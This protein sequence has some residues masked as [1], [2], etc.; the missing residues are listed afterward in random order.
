MKQ[1]FE[2]GLDEYRMMRWRNAR[3][4]GRYRELNNQHP[5]DTKYGVFF[6]FGKQQ[7]A[8]GLQKLI[9]RGYINEGEEQKL[10]SYA[11]FLYG[12][13]SELK[14]FMNSYEE[15]RKRIAIECD[16]QEVYCYEFNNFECGTAFDGDLNA[17]L[18]VADIWGTDKA[19]TITRA[20]VLYSTEELFD[21][22]TE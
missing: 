22:T 21:K 13:P 6:A 9:S 10:A 19:R 17:I 11:G 2:F 8:E 15:R 18:H 3:T 16:P 20:S 4:L 5:D 12:L 14:R 7:F 1:A